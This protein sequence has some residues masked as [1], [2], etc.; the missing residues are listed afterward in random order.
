VAIA[1]GNEHAAPAATKVQAVT[2]TDAQVRQKLEAQ[3]YTNVQIKERDK[4]HI[5]V[6]A[7]RNGKSEKLAVNPQ[8]G[9]VMPDTD[10]DDRKPEQAAVPEDLA[11]EQLD[12]R[13]WPPLPYPG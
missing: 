1:A 6:T 11:H 4:G 9:Q 8:S 12:P 13:N 5:D 10:N 3:G 7:A 2:M